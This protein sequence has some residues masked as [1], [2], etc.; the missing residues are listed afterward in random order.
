L[1][2][3]EVDAQVI[4]QAEVAQAAD[5]KLRFTGFVTALRAAW[6]KVKG[7]G[8]RV[9]AACLCSPCVLKFRQS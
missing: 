3:A 5:H 9:G 2:L 7:L 6:D 8:G 1:R 4:Y